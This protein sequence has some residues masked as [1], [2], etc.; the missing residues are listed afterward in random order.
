MLCDPQSVQWNWPR[1]LG[2]ILG[3][4]TMCGDV[5]LTNSMELNYNK[6]LFQKLLLSGKP[7]H[8]I[9]V[10]LGCFWVVWF[11]FLVSKPGITLHSCSTK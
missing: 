2:R 3:L 10:L 8:A 4:L 5:I 1:L 9:Q 6:V 11:F 7:C